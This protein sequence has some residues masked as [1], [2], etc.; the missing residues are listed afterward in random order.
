M[1]DVF[2]VQAEVAEQ[3]AEELGVALADSTRRELVTRPT[4][5]LDAYDLFLRAEAAALAPRRLDPVSLRAAIPLYERAVALD[6]SFAPAWAQLAVA[7][8]FLYLN[9]G[10]TPE[11]KVQARAAADR[12]AAL[13]PGKTESVVAMATYYRNIEQKLEPAHRVVSAAHAENPKD[14]RLLGTLGSLEVSL[15]RTEKGLT[16]LREAHRLDPRS[17][18]ISSSIGASLLSLRRFEAADSLFGRAFELEPDNLNVILSRVQARLGQ[19][20]LAGARALVNTAAAAG[21][22]RTIAVYLAT[23]L[24]LFWVLDS[25][26]QALV[27]GSRI[28]DFEGDAGSWGLAHANILAAWGDR[29]RSRSYADSGRAAFAR[30]LAATPDDA[31]LHSLLGLTLA[32]MGRTDEAIEHAKRGT[33][34]LPAEQNPEIGPYLEEILA[35]IYVMAGQ[36]ERAVERLEVVLAHPWYISRAWLKIDP[37][38]AP[39]RNHPAFLRLVS[40]AP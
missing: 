20:D 13:A 11:L 31:Q 30:D 16:L 26:Q 3:V 4:K 34:L 36:P 27:V 38:Y 22:T 1:T 10:P 12:A 5:N 2:E 37:H 21:D 14:P 9:G 8:S 29:A 35:R 19:G 24:E 6:S 32:L 39:I 7:R 40:G 17:V 25:A 15:G 23:Y 28:E 33:A 18:T